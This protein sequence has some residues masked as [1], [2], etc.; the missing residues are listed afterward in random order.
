M[1]TSTRGFLVLILGGGLSRLGWASC[2]SSCDADGDGYAESPTGS[3][4]QG[5]PA[6][7]DCDDGDQTIN[8]GMAEDGIGFV[9]E[10]CDG[11]TMIHRTW[12]SGMDLNVLA[13]HG[14]ENPNISDVDWLNGTSAIPA[15]GMAVGSPAGGLREVTIVW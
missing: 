8:P 15:T 9:D 4:C 1:R 12:V 10:D 2:P 5:C 11:S 13:G 6:A 3:G 7:A 14:L